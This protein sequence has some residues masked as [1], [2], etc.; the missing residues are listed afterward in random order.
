MNLEGEERRLQRMALREGLSV[1]ELQA[2][3]REAAALQKERQEEGV[4][5]GH[6]E[7]SDGEGSSRDASPVCCP[8]GPGRGDSDDTGR[9]GRRMVD[10]EGG[11]WREEDGAEEPEEVPFWYADPHALPHILT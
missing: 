6:S 2:I 10:G 7:H 9:S 11:R 4:R 3:E 8:R 5:R 1:E